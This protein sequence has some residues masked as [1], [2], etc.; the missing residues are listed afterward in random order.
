ML[1]G[2]T[3][4]LKQGKYDHAYRLVALC[5]IKSKN[6]S[7]Y[8]WKSAY[9]NGISENY[10]NASIEFMKSIND[11]PA[12]DHATREKVPDIN[13]FC[14]VELY[15]GISHKNFTRNLYEVFPKALAS[16]KRETI[17]AYLLTAGNYYATLVD[18]AFVYRPG[19]EYRIL[20]A[21]DSRTCEKCGEMDGKAFCYEDM[22][23]G[24]N[25]PPFHEK[26]RCGIVGRLDADIEARMTRAARDPLTGMN[27]PIPHMTYK[28]WIKSLSPKQL[29]EI[30]IYKLKE[31]NKEADK[32]QYSQ[33]KKAL[34]KK[35]PTGYLKFQDFK[36]RNPEYFAEL[37]GILKSL[38]IEIK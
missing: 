22:H 4:F 10:L 1:E 25:A 34:G 12:I 15:S 33:F 27:Y 38:A 11:V 5:W 32:I 24:V 30:R 17:E 16:I 3:N 6:H 18:A 37:E 28:E 21:L 31:L 2:A 9:R 14:L 7:L 35:V 36:Y 8:D 19:K 29:D 20:S 23:T 13:I 26:C